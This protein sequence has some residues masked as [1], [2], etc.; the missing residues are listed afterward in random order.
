MGQNNFLASNHNKI[1]IHI[2]LFT[3]GSTK[4]KRPSLYQKLLQT[5]IIPQNVMGKSYHK[6]V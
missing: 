4:L 1:D 6:N 2:V 3:Y 5:Q